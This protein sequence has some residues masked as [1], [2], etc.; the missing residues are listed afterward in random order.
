MEI[1]LPQNFPPTSRTSEIVRSKA[2]LREIPHRSILTSKSHR[3]VG[4]RFRNQSHPD[5]ARRAAHRFDPF[6]A[7]PST[8]SSAIPVPKNR[9]HDLTIMDYSRENFG[10]QKRCSP[11]PLLVRRREPEWFWAREWDLESDRIR[12]AE[13]ARVHG[14]LRSRLSNCFATTLTGPAGLASGR[15]TDGGTLVTSN[16]KEFQRVPG[17]QVEDWR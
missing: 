8:S 7:K 16:G 1:N 6:A 2:G 5:R 11:D 10:F 14:A 3:I 13:I 9:I 12:L 17:L 15:N 4:N